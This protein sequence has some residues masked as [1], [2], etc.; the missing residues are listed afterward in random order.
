MKQLRR[1]IL[2][3]ATLVVA[4]CAIVVT[5]TVVTRDPGTS[6]MTMEP[7][8]VDEWRQY[9]EVGNRIGPESASWT[10]VEFGDYQCPACR[11]LEP[12]LRAIR[13][14]Y[15]DDLAIVYRHWPLSIHPAAYSAA[16][17]VEC[18]AAVGSFDVLH[19]A[20]YSELKW[21]EEGMDDIVQDVGLADSDAF[22]EYRSQA[23]PHPTVEGDIEAAMGLET[24]GTPTLIINGVMDAEMM[25]SI[26]IEQILLETSASAR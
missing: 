4:V 10:I 20:L 11:G 7:R 17:A 8:E 14:K 13:N 15:P 16:R 1:A 21:M 18:A 3:G 5:V 26:R 24:P 25:D 2:D 6:S 22:Q 23:D 19:E 12:H 9:A